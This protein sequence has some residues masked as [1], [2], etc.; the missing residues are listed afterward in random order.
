MLTVRIKRV[1]R[2]WFLFHCISCLFLMGML[3]LSFLGEFLCILH[4]IVWR[5]HLGKLFFEKGHRKGSVHAD[6]HF[7]FIHTFWLLIIHLHFLILY[8]GYL[9]GKK[10][11][12]AYNLRYTFRFT[13]VKTA[14]SIKRNPI[15]PFFLSFLSSY[16]HKNLILILL[17]PFYVIQSSFF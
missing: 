3:F 4:C 13:G 11:N 1:I 14:E 16:F 17:L 2:C 8:Y 5:N 10:M 6:L 9:H 12:S 15:S 7:T